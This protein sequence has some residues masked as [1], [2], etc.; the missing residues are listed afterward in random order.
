ME[1]FLNILFLVLGLIFLV[2]GAD[3]FVSGASAIAKKLKVP[4]I[5]IGLTI[6]AIGTSLP[7]LAVGISGAISGNTDVAIGNVVGS[8][9]SNIFFILGMVAIIFPITFKRSNKKFD[10]PFLAIVT[11]A[12]LVFCCDTIFDDFDSNIIS[13]V[14]SI[15]LLLMFVFYITFNIKNTRKTKYNIDFS[16]NLVNNEVLHEKELK[17]WQIVLYVVLGL[18]AV[19]FGGECVSRT[20]QFIASKAGMSDTLIGLTIVAVGTSL[21][22]LA[23]SIAA[24][25]KHETDIAVGNVLGSN[26]LNIILIIG[27]IGII[28]PIVVSTNL[29]IELCILF[30]LTTFFSIL[31]IFKKKLSRREG[32]IFVV[33]YILYIATAIIKNYCF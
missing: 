13:R 11:G 7:E 24:A 32:I 6:V 31:A 26:I 28:R 8:N 3:F 10:L 29:I 12:L 22:E 30:V 17:V 23:T 18:A 33:I 27:S 15:F 4:S 2:F 9:I 16:D 1:I 20:S 25:R 5:V 14:E 21:P 19:V